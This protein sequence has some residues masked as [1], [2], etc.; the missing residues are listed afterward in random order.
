MGLYLSGRFLWAYTRGLGWAYTRRG[1]YTVSYK[2]D[3]YIK[4]V[5][6]QNRGIF[7]TAFTFERFWPYSFITDSIIR[8]SKTLSRKCKQLSFNNYVPTA[9]LWMF[10]VCFC[11]YL[12][13]F[14]PIFGRLWWLLHA[15]CYSNYIIAVLSLSAD[16]SQENWKLYKA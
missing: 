7:P 14:I 3:S 6:S 10:P 2:A 16:L 15:L 5:I 4:S 8:F 11:S 12:T 1:L 13:L 9:R